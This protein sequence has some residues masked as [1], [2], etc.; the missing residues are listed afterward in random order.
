ML[1]GSRR[2]KRSTPRCFACR[3]QDLCLVRRCRRGVLRRTTKHR[4]VCAGKSLLARNPKKPWR[5]NWSAVVFGSSAMPRTCRGD[6]IWCCVDG[7][8][9]YLY[10]DV[11]GTVARVTGPFPSTIVN[12]GKSKS[13]A[14]ASETV[15][16]PNSCDDRVGAFCKC[17]NT[18]TPKEPANE[19]KSGRVGWR[20][21]DDPKNQA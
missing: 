11:S 1:R 12:G 3:H 20:R 17:G 2:L 14:I 18:K 19:F 21:E 16:G 5:Q 10:T 4:S 8:S 15:E 6:R 7:A 13:N 9:P